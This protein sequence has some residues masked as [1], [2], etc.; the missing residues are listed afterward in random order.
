MPILEIS[1]I[2][3]LLD[4]SN[5]IVVHFMALKHGALII[6]T[7]N[8]FVSHGTKVFETLIFKVI[9]YYAYLGSWAIVR[10]ASYSLSI[11]TTHI[12]FSMFNTEK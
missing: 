12:S 4:C 5:H 9:I 8:E 7:L 3:L 6:Q 2:M 11:A 10:T 1:S